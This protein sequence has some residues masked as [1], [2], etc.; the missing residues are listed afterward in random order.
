[1]QPKLLEARDL[2]PDQQA[3]VETIMEFVEDPSA[4]EMLVEGPAGSGKTSSIRVSI[5]E[6][7]KAYRSGVV[8]RAPTNKAVKVARELSG[9]LVDT[10]TIYKLLSLSPQA[11]GEVKEIRQGEN[12][13]QK[14]MATELVYLDEASM[15]GSVLKPF[16]RRAQEDYGIK[17]VY[18]ADRYQLPPVGEDLSWVFREVRSRVVLDKVKR[19]DNQILNLA[20]HLREVIDGN[21]KLKV[22]DDFTEEHGGIELFTRSKAFDERILDTWEATRR[23]AGDAEPD[24]S[25]SRVLAWRN[26][27]VGGY[28]D[29]VREM[30][31]GRRE[32]RDNP[33]MVGERVVVCNPV[34]SLQEDNVT[35]MHTDEEG[36]IEK[37]S[38]RPHPKY[39]E[40]ECFALVVL[41][42]SNGEPCGV[43]TPT[44]A[45]QKVVERML[46]N[47]KQ[48]AE[49]ED[50]VFWG[51]FWRL[52]ELMNDVRPC[53][54]LTTHRSQGSTFRETFINLDDILANR[55][56]IEALKSAYVAVTRASHKA[57]IKWGGF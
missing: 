3:A 47:F 27:A 9:G 16:I 45:G 25:G 19:H 13:H 4:S 56:S 37:I 15:N 44:P 57:N 41:R 54:A 21:A 29:L 20:T 30:L 2:F 51:A 12:A 14:L 32:A 18:I 52:K 46:R 53:H 26:Q 39:P 6:L 49:R 55:N 38:I 5:N 43:F 7:P 22:A 40:I 50:R 35:L 34:L 8:V 31:Y 48:K 24:F 11:N 42:E 1:M 10:T 36:F 17:F 28:N 23:E 33:L